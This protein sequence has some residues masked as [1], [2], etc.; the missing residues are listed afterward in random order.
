MVEQSEKR[1]VV[2]QNQEISEI[3]IIKLPEK[4]EYIQNKEKINLKTGKLLI[5]YKDGTTKEVFMNNKDVSVSGFDNSIVGERAIRITYKGKQTTFVV[6][7]VED[8]S[9][10]DDTVANKSLPNAGMK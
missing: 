4:V 5:K 6:Y 8:I 1:P 7:I 2:D 9:S 3:S 10:S